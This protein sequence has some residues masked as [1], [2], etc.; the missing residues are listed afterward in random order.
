MN[1]SSRLLYLVVPLRVDT[2][3]IFIMVVM[4]PVNTVDDNMR[5]F[6]GKSSPNSMSTL[7]SHLITCVRNFIIDD[8]ISLVSLAVDGHTFAASIALNLFLRNASVQRTYV[9]NSGADRRLL[10][11][12]SLLRRIPSGRAKFTSSCIR[13]RGALL[14]HLFA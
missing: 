13:R 6:L 10:Y 9:M 5:T 2:L 3:T 1:L 4:K 7:N 12:Y 11:N 14:F 8:K